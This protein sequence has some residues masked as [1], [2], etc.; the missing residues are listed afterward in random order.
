MSRSE[1][2]AELTEF[3]DNFKPEEFSSASCPLADA[4]NVELRLKQAAK[5]KGRLLRKKQMEETFLSALEAGL[6]AEESVTIT[7]AQIDELLARA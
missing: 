2:L 1:D 6:A 7:Q 5:I 4:A 3:I